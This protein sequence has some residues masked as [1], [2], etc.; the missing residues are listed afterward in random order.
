M[1]QGLG[2]DHQD[3]LDKEL[4]ETRQDLLKQVSD[5]AKQI[6]AFQKGGFR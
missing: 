1:G 5:S 6:C 3:I 4:L 2:F